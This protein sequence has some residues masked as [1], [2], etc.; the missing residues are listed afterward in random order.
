ML[1]MTKNTVI[2]V[3]TKGEVDYMNG[4]LT[5]RCPDTLSDALTVFCRER[6]LGRAYV[7]RRA[8]QTYIETV[9]YRE[10]QTDAVYRS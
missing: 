3:P 7:I 1:N 9:R 4:R 8:L 6:G 5:A 2:D 10:A